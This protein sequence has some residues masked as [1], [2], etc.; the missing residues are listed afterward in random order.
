MSATAWPNGLCAALVLSVYSSHSALRSKTRR[1]LA[2][3]SLSTQY[4]PPG[5]VQWACRKVSSAWALSRTAWPSKPAPGQS[6]SWSV[7][8]T[9]YPRTT[10][11]TCPHTARAGMP[12]M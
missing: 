10:P 9:W 1:K 4:E 3:G 5:R 6:G 12:D 7:C 11:P 2:F 8:T